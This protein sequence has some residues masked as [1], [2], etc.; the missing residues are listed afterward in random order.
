MDMQTRHQD[1]LIF[2]L[3]GTRSGDGLRGIDGLGLRPALLAPYR[4]LSALRHDF[5][6]VLAP[7][8]SREFVQSLSSMVNA[9]LRDVAPRGIEGERLRRHGLQLERHIRTAVADGARGELSGLWAAAASALVAGAGHDDDDAL[10]R[11]AEAPQL[12]GQERRVGIDHLPRQD[13]VADD[14]DGGGLVTHG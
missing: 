9:V 8:D 5:P 10:Q 2:H 11:H 3:S 7:P 13:L 6:V 4:E 12:L 1:Q 14:D